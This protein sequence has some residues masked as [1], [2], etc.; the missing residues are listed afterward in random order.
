MGGLKKLGLLF[1][2]VFFVSAC[3]P[4][5]LRLTIIEVADPPGWGKLADFSKGE[6]GAGFADGFGY[7][8]DISDNYAIVGAPGVDGEGLDRGAAYIYAR[9]GGSW[10]W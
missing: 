2:C 9:S 5:G 7:S 8:V 6:T 4:I 1:I 3:E 10:D